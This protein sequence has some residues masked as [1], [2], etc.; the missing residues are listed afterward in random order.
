M[1]GR[2]NKRQLTEYI[3]YGIVENNLSPKDIAENTISKII[4]EY[5]RN[6]SYFENYVIGEL[7]TF[8]RASC[9]LLAINKVGITE[10]KQVNA[11][12]A[13]D[14]AFKMCEK[15]YYYTGKHANEPKKLEEVDFKKCFSQDEESWNTSRGTLVTAL[16]KGKNND[17]LA[18]HQNLELTYTRAVQLKKTR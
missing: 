3:F 2:S 4:L 7:D 8:K 15:P 12:V 14:A 11:S 6:A 13:L 17:I 16:S 10:D 9:L 1:E 18:Y 5:S